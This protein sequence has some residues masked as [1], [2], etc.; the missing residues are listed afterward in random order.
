MEVG[1]GSL[2]SLNFVRDSK[3]EKEIDRKSVLYGISSESIAAYMDVL[4]EVLADY[5]ACDEFRTRNAL[6]NFLRGKRYYP[7]EWLIKMLSEEEKD[8][9]QRFETVCANLKNKMLGETYSARGLVE[10]LT[11]FLERACEGT[12]LPDEI[13]KAIQEKLKDFSHLRYRLDNSSGAIRLHLIDFKHLLYVAHSGVG[14]ENPIGSGLVSIIVNSDD[15]L[16]LLEEVGRQTNVLTVS[17]KNERGRFERVVTWHAIDWCIERL[18][19]LIWKINKE[20]NSSLGRRVLPDLV[21]CKQELEVFKRA[22]KYNNF[23]QGDGLAKADIKTIRSKIRNI[24]LRFKGRTDEYER[25]HVF[26][27]LSSIESF[28][29]LQFKTLL[30]RDEMYKDVIF[31]LS[32]IKRNNTLYIASNK[33]GKKLEFAFGEENLSAMLASNLKC[34]NFRVSNN[35][36]VHCEA[37]AGNGR[38]D[39]TVYQ[40]SRTMAII[41]CKLAREGASI[42]SKIIDAVDQLYAR[43][44]ENEYADSGDGIQLFLIVFSHDRG[45]RA[46][47]NSVTEALG[48]YAVRNSLTYEQLGSSENGVTFS[49]EEDRGELFLKKKRVINL[50]VSNL[51]VDFHIRAKDRKNLK[52]YGL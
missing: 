26:E 18:R 6:G 8:Y 7:R 1:V 39:I 31:S 27:G 43:Y 36:T 45:F 33:K 4:E 47:A 16:P 34:M 22:I 28:L 17:L 25:H 49:Y 11:H 38:C 32:E 35:I 15:V 21:E 3:I 23:L 20:D 10:H 30:Q 24:S 29:R 40:G 13:E 46:V 52:S 50:I 9:W 14:Y 37:L 19:T 5:Q 44:S 42:E 2:F 12:C 51:E 41:E 48:K